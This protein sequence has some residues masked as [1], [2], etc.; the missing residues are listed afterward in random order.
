MILSY[1]TLLKRHKELIPL[2]FDRNVSL[3]NPASIDI[4][5]GRELIWGKY[6]VDLETTSEQNPVYLYKGEFYLIS[7]LEVL[8]VP[9]D[10]AMELKL[11]SSRAREGFN[12]SLAFW[13]DPGWYGIGT[14]EIT[15]LVNS[16]RIWKGM[17]IAQLIYH[18][19]DE[20]CI[21]SYVGKY[22]NALTVETAKSDNNSL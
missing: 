9:I 7:T 15:S 8:A 19:L 10:L 13:F 18:K 12:H 16:V 17:K 2:E 4:R 1:Q 21:K 11:K 5:I 20:P 14:M 3:I 6:K 22:Q